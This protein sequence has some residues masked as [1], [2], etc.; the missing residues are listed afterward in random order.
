VGTGEFNGGRVLKRERDNGSEEELD[1][2]DAVHLMA[3]SDRTIGWRVMVRRPSGRVPTGM[4]SSI[5]TFRTKPILIST[6]HSTTATPI[7]KSSGK[8][9]SSG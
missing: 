2:E 5:L 3:R 9:P 6:S 1:E 8:S 7:L 4:S